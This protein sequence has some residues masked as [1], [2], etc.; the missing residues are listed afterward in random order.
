MPTLST[1]HSPA[2]LRAEIAIYGLAVSALGAFLL[3]TAPLGRAPGLL[4]VAA[5]GLLLWSGIEYAL[6]RFVQHRMA[7]FARWHL[8]DSPQALARPGRALAGAL[9]A[10]LL[11]TL[12]GM[13]GL[14][15]WWLLGALNT[16]ALALGLCTGYLGY[17]VMHQ[18]VHRA[19]EREQ[20]RQ[21]IRFDWLQHKAVWH[22]HHHRTNPPCC[23]GVSTTLWDRVFG[24]TGHP[25]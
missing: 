3:L 13:A 11:A 10:A 15:A 5:L 19:A 16:S 25:H 6:H 23:Y 24:T 7:P 20:A 22:A 1:E 4:V 17:T 2:A 18:A 14:V 21:P 9:V 8:P 12:A